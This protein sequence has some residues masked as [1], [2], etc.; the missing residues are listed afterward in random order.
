[1]VPNGCLPG[2]RRDGIATRKRKQGRAYETSRKRGVPSL[3]L[4]TGSN[5][6][7]L[8]IRY[9]EGRGKA[10]KRKDYWLNFNTA[11]C[12]KPIDNDYKETR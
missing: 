12:R 1:M 9:R 10:G 2:Q 7:F 11:H 5:R 4:A 8:R 3:Q 6:V